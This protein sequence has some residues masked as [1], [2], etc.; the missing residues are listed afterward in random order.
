MDNQYNQSQFKA[1][2]AQPQMPPT[3]PAP[4]TAPSSPLAQ[5]QSP[6]AAPAPP[7]QNQTIRANAQYQASAQAFTQANYANK[8]I[9]T[10][11][12]KPQS[13]PKQTPNNPNSTQNH[14]QFANFKDNMIIMKDASFRSVISCKAINFDLMSNNEREGVEF[15]YQGFL[16]S[17]Y[18]PI[19][20]LIRSN[21]VDIGP[22]LDKLV[23]IRSNQDNM[24]LNILMD[25]YIRYIEFLAQEANIMD[26]NFYIVIPY[27]SSNEDLSDLKN[28][29]KGFFNGLLG[30]NNQQ[31]VVKINAKKFVK[32][33]E[34]LQ[35]RTD[36]VINGLAQVGVKA[37]RLNT[38]QLSQL[39]YTFYNPS[40][41]NQE[42]IIDF[43][44]I[45]S[46]YTKKGDNRDLEKKRG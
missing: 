16:N 18:F 12:K 30:N 33:K 17:L 4:M 1:P 10:E 38:Q 25:D 20:I 28:A 7:V 45:A 35:N 15:G 43:N 21:K 39:F 23:K 6:L 46:V 34:E 3:A 19:Q 2:V 22:Y 24:L 37:Q 29:P 36:A 31:K 9:P 8:N 5:P 42:P 14:L 32:A 13:K 41:S 26:K 27:F 11:P 44:N 40:I